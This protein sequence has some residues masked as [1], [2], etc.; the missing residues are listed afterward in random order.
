MPEKNICPNCGSPYV[1]DKQGNFVCKYCGYIKPESTSGEEETLLY[2]AAQSLRLAAFDEARDMYEDIVERFPKCAEAH[3][4]LT[5]CQYGIKFEDDPRTSKKIP[6]CYATQYESFLDNPS[7]KKALSFA[8]KEQREF[9]VRTAEAIEKTRQEWIEKAEKE[10]PYDIFLS[11]KDTDEDGKRTD[12]SYDAHEIYNTLTG[13]GYRVFF[14]RVTLAGKTGEH[15][16]PYIFAALNSAP[17]MLV[18]ASK[19]EYVT[20]TWIK[21]EWNRYLARIR[22]GDKQ[23]GS[24]A[25]IF[26]NFSPSALPRAL[27]G[28]QNLKYG[29]L[30]FLSNLKTYVDKYI[31]AARA[32]SPQIKR[33]EIALAKKQG[34]KSLEA[35][36]TETVSSI[37]KREHVAPISSVERR[38]IGGSGFGRLSANEES[39]LTQAGIYLSRKD[40]DHAGSLYEEVLKKSPNNATAYIGKILCSSKQ[41]DLASWIVDECKDPS[42]LEQGLDMVGHASEEE[43]TQILDGYAKACVDLSKEKHFEEA[44]NLFNAIADFDT[45]SINALPK[46]SFALADQAYQEND[47]PHS[48]DLAF[49]CL[50]YLAADKK[51]YR[52]AFLELINSSLIRKDYEK[53]AALFELYQNYFDLEVGQY[54]LFLQAK[55]KFGNFG[56]L[57]THVAESGDFTCFS[58]GL[59]LDQNNIDALFDLLSDETLSLIQNKSTVSA[60]CVRFLL[61]YRFPKRDAFVR[62]V[63][64]LCCEA[65]GEES[66]KTLDEVLPAFGNDAF[67]QFSKAHLRFVEAAERNEN[68]DLALRYL[69]KLIDYDPDNAALY[70][71][72][73][74]LQLGCREQHDLPNHLDQFQDFHDVETLLGLRGKKKVSDVLHPYLDACLESKNAKEAARVFDALAVYF[75]EEESHELR[76]YLEKMALYCKENGQFEYAEKYYST[77][78]S[79]NP[80][81]HK[82]YWG[83]LQSKLRCKKEEDLVACDTPLGELVEFENAKLATGGDTQALTHYIDIEMAQTDA[84][85]KRRDA[86]ENRRRLEEHNAELRRQAE[87]RKKK[88]RKRIAWISTLSAIVLVAS[89]VTA[90]LA[91]TM[92]IPQGKVSS[93][94]ASIKKG[95]YQEAIDAL[96]GVSY[97]ESGNLLNM[98]YAGSSF[99]SGDYEQG[100][101]YV[102]RSGGD[103]TVHY[104]AKDGTSEKSE[105]TI[106]PKKKNVNNVAFKAGYD[107]TWEQTKF[108]INVDGNYHADL[109]LEAIYTIKTYSI[110]YSLGGGTNSDKNPTT[111]TVEDGFTLTAPTREGYTFQGWVDETGEKVEA[112]NRGTTG[113]L[114][115]T[116]TW[117]DGNQYLLHLDASGGEI[118]TPTITVQFGK[119]YVLPAPTRKGYDFLGWQKEGAK[120]LFPSQG[121]WQWTNITKLTA[122]WSICN[123]AITYENVA[124]V[125]ADW[126]TSYTVN[127]EVLL[128]EAVRDGYTFLGWTDEN[129]AAVTSIP[130]GSI[131]SRVFTATWNDGNAYQITLVPG[132]GASVD[133]K[134]IN[135]QYDHEYTLPTPTKKGYE[136][137]GWFEDESSS[138]FAASG[139]W[140]LTSN[141]TLTAKWEIITYTITY[142][143]AGG[144]LDEGAKTSY[145]VEDHFTL[146]EPTKDKYTF[147]GWYD[148]KENKVTSIE[149]GSTGDLKLTASWEKTKY[150][151]SV[152]IDGEAHGSFTVYDEG[153]ALAEEVTDFSGK[154]TRDHTVTLTAVPDTGYLLR[155]WYDS[156][157]RV[158]ED[159]TYHFWISD[160]NVSLTAIF[161]TEAEKQ[162]YETRMIAIGG[163]PH[164]TGT[165]TMT[166]GMYPQTIA[167]SLDSTLSSLPKDSS[168]WVYYNGSY[169]ARC[170][171]AQG[172]IVDT[173]SDNVTK[174]VKG[175]SH[176]FKCEPI[177]WKRVSGTNT[178]L[179]T[180][181][182]DSHV[183]NSTVTTESDNFGTSTIY[184]WL[185]N[186]FARTAFGHGDPFYLTS[187]T[188]SN[189]ASTHETNSASYED[190]SGRFFLPHYD[191]LYNAYR[192]AVRYGTDYAVAKGAYY[193]VY[194][195]FEM[196]YWTRTGLYD[197]IGTDGDSIYGVSTMGSL[198]SYG[199]TS[200]VY[201]VTA[202]GIGV[203][204]GIF[205]PSTFF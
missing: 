183:Y 81:E 97:G 170:T 54:V 38:Q 179:S 61:P 164:K 83:L 63:V 47:A 142:D 6:T 41:P 143:C 184:T 85:K 23:E 123:Y 77:L 87:I 94:T 167:A 128:P 59:P 191:D 98:A 11:F 160:E 200:G 86:E 74:E 138:A 161:W 178:Y 201:K 29:E 32:S 193:Y 124:S 173:Y 151:L 119:A 15:Y 92:F 48:Y 125:P 78:I 20:S 33:K 181:V 69:T 24:L 95:N 101:D 109:W 71:K 57:L 133:S 171:S 196:G 175:E 72:R 105:E 8:S 50:K 147:L 110:T 19:P 199:S 84:I 62:Q 165:D 145:T 91:F 46:D 80:M 106:R 129:G 34:Q 182:L 53:S 4:G 132:D 82:N 7:Y 75:P 139:T 36:K 108:Q 121:T 204:V 60:A 130:T 166:Y 10:P 22:S 66:A 117:N 185:H 18:F 115:L 158:S 203:C 162:E 131:G 195:G 79:M 140:K 137:L 56:E 17:V 135:V 172:S 44:L 192:K 16:E 88:T 152:A 96:T 68:Y 51:A 159:S 3:W 148:E 136:F 39:K 12:D 70:H 1:L 190:C 194:K 55:G 99:S 126:P 67:D 186:D 45:P 155:G 30:T 52:D 134:L 168:G 157:G 180:M 25:V 93:A 43:A 2:A 114:V 187:G 107:S 111:Y 146:L 189:A 28:L 102:L 73:I 31:S 188:I 42:K 27:S 113:D 5:L 65:P 112:I 174:I 90:T 198:S 169:Y 26:R 144:T 177:V 197:G 154:I 153:V 100:I 89:G 9:F 127:D 14:S 156:N 118:E 76:G 149:T 163:L 141:L 58:E 40:F 49:A 150:L 104:D 116:A 103:T 122:T 176:W 13:L 202:T 37:S 21:N 35:V 64:D 205:E 120:D